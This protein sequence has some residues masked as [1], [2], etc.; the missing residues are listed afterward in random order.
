VYDVILTAYSQDANCADQVIV[1]VDVIVVS[2]DELDVE[3]KL[4]PNPTSGAVMF[5]S[6]TTINRIELFGLDGRILSTHTPQQTRFNLDVSGW[7][8][9]VYVARIITP[10]GVKSV[11]LIR[12]AR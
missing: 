1:E 5:E 2:V 3:A 9:G 7:P 4:W 6:N 10:N 11:Q 12:A 8:A